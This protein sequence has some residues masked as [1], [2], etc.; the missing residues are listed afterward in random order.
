MTSPW[1]KAA[2]CGKSSYKIRPARS[3]HCCD[4]ILT[5]RDRLHKYRE[6][7]REGG[8]DWLE[9]KTSAAENWGKKI[10]PHEC[11]RGGFGVATSVKPDVF[12]LRTRVHLRWGQILSRFN[13][14]SCTEEQDAARWIWIESTS[15][16]DMKCLTITTN[17]DV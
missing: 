9:G 5:E 11:R 6:G 17:F 2:A 8:R 12:P 7:L 4:N 15:W 14:P 3:D 1:A 10:P 13:D 16:S